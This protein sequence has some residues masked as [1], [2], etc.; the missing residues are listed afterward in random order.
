MEN[1]QSVVNNMCIVLILMQAF[2]SSWTVAF[3]ISG[4]PICGYS[5]FVVLVLVLLVGYMLV[6][7]ILR[8]SFLVFFRI[9]AGG[10]NN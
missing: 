1:F 10:S 2:F 4:L 3:T 7:I 6:P 9:L 8:T 5:F